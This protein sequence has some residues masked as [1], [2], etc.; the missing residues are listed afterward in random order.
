[1]R[2]T[3][4]PAGI[5]SYRWYHRRD[6][7]YENCGVFGFTFEVEADLETHDVRSEAYAID[8]LRQPD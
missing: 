2:A 1:L 3:I 8:L 6:E 5:D 7:I 4:A